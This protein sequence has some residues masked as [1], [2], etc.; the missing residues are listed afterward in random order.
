M[1]VNCKH[2]NLSDTIMRNKPFLSTREQ[3]A[4]AVFHVVQNM[5]QLLCYKH[6]EFVGKSFLSLSKLYNF[7]QMKS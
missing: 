6:N 4:V 5:L 2:T 1:N 7:R 3:M